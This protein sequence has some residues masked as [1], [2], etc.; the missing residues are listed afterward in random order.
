MNVKKLG[1]ISLLTAL[2]TIGAGVSVAP[3]SAHGLKKAYTNCKTHPNATGC[4]N[5]NPGST[6][7][8]GTGG[9][10][11][12]GSSGVPS[13]GGG[14]TA[15]VAGAPAASAGTHSVV[16]GVTYGNTSAGSTQHVN[17]LPFT[18]GGAPAAP[19]GNSFL[20]L[21]GGMLAALG[22]GIRRVLR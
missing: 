11:A 19:V 6:G 18:G 17:A 8:A 7:G 4:K 14:G 12:P 22:F 21:L 10:Q 2:F 1:T 13:T 9:G 15:P 3:A 16:T 20:M 5:Q